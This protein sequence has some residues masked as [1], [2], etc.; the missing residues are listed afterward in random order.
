MSD[1]WKP[2]DLALCIKGGRIANSGRPPKSFPVKGRIYTVHSSRM[3]TFNQ[4]GFSLG[5]VLEDGPVNNCGTRIWHHSRFV[6]LPEHT[7]DEEDR[8]TIRLFNQELE[9]ENR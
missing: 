5:L 2:G 9:H 8:E 1:D 7:E 3:R 6:K 4:A